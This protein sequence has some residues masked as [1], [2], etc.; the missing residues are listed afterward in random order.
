MQVE[1]VDFV[2][3]PTRDTARA[4]G[5]YRDVLGLPVSEFTEGEIETP[6]LT[7]SFWEPE[8]DGEPF[9]PIAAGIA[10]RVPDV[11]AAVEEARAGG[12]E[13]R[14]IEDTGVCHMGFV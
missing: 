13:V 4:V 9:Q 11:A 14:G 1:Q 8:K 7:L 5:W 12:A 2:C 10:L 3:V 6:N